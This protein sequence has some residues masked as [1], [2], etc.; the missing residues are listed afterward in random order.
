MH[1]LLLHASVPTA[2]HVQVLSILAGVAAMQPQPFHERHL[3]YKPTRPPTK[4]VVQIGGSQ[5][6]QQN[7]AQKA[8][9]G[10]Q[11]DLF[12]L[13]LVEN[14]VEDA[15]ERG[16]SNGG[17]VMDEVDGLSGEGEASGSIEKEHLLNT[18]HDPLDNDHESSTR[19]TFQF[20]DVPEPGNRRPCTS[21]LMGDTPITSGDAHAFMSAM[22][23]THTSTH[24]LVGHRLTH[25]STSILLFRP[26]RP[27]SSAQKP[28]PID[29]HTYI[30]QVSIRVSNGIAKP[31][32]MS[33]GVKELLNLKEMLRG[34]VE[35]ESVERGM[36]DTR[37]R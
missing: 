33:R 5:A 29:P 25:L 1:E 34:V 9:A 10:T 21:R 17:A 37:V 14:L 12:Y 27:S 16:M 4:A 6:V 20:R 11:E 28:E 36:L 19:W 18:I 22:E 7:P 3:I 32:L 15:E 31:Q 26:C 35:L 13:H 30:L 2:R 24:H 23:Y 8:K